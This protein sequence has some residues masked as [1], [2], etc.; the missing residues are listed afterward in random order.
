M[1]VVLMCRQGVESGVVVCFRD[2]G[3]SV[4]CYDVDVIVDFFDECCCVYDIGDDCL[5]S[6]MVDVVEDAVLNG[7]TA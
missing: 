5:G 6:L 3:V 4:S 1:V 2:C 7:F